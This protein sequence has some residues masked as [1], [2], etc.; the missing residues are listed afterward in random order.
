[1]LSVLIKH[2]AIGRDVLYE[3]ECVEMQEALPGADNDLEPGL[4]IVRSDDLSAHL[5][6]SQTS[7]SSRDVFV[8]NSAGQ[9]IARYTL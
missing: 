7:E 2:K 4:L 5:G 9:T 8:M 6:M 1:M 3:A